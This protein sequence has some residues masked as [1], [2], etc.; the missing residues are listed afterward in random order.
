MGVGG[1]GTGSPSS[2]SG[3]GSGTGSGG[4][5]D[6]PPATATVARTTLTE[7][8]QVQGTL[9]YA[10][11][12]P[13][14]SRVGGTLTWVPA[15]G[16]TVALGQAVFQVDG[17]PIVLIHGLVPPYRTLHT[18]VEGADVAQL[19]QSL[20]DLGYTGFEVDDTYTWS[21]ATAVTQWQDDLGVEQTGTVEVGDLVVAAGDVRVAEHG[22]PPG[23]VLSG[24]ANETVLTV[25]GTTRVVTV[26]LDVAEQHLVH[27][28]VHATVTLPDDTEV[29]GT[30]AGVGTVATP[31]DASDESSPE[32]AAGAGASGSSE[33]A[34]V[35][36]TIGIDD[37]QA[38]GTYDAAPVDVVLVSDTRED[39]LAVPVA[40]LVALAEGGYG[41]EV[42]DGDRVSYVAVDTGM[43][44]GGQ[45]EISGDGIAEGTVVGVP[46]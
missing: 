43:F 38:L 16:A 34:T 24:G 37:Q 28:G 17:E 11:T 19:E 14:T 12:Q 10:G 18:G 5:G 20:A 8:E 2:G 30:V 25:S 15:E 27:Q 31:A 22:L 32:N 26:D 33:P 36:V 44:A 3:S 40:A 1:G 23:S 6:L 42:V 29:G 35:T 13:V 9:A 4:A 39:V 41:V 7:T 45:V 21:T 46:S